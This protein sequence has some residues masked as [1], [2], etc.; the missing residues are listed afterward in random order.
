[1]TSF[2]L[3]WHYL[4]PGIRPGIEIL[5][6]LS[7][8]V[9]LLQRR[10]R[11]A[12]ALG[13]ILG[14]A[15]LP[16]P[17]LLFWWIVGFEHL[18]S[19]KDERR[20]VSM[21]S[22]RKLESL[23][24]AIPSLATGPVDSL[25]PLTHLPDE[26]SYGV[27]EPSRG[28]ET[29]LL[30]D[31]EDFYGKLREAISEAREHIHCL[32][33][34]WRH[35]ATGREFRDLLAARSRAGVRV[36]LLLDGLGSFRSV[37]RFMDPLRAAGASVEPFL[38]LR[39]SPNHWNVNFRNHR[40]L[41]VIDG[42]TGFLGGLNIGDE[43]RTRWHDLALRLRGPVVDQIQ[44]IFVDDWAYAT[45][46]NLHELRYFRGTEF[47]ASAEEHLS[48]CSVVASGP[49]MLLNVTLEA[50]FASINAATKRIWIFTP[51]FI[52]DSATFMALRSAV[53]RGADVRLLV[54]RRSNH[55]IA[56][57]AAKS[58]YPDLLRAG[59]RIFEYGAAFLHGK[60][61]LFDDRLAVIGSANFDVRS[62]RLNFEASCF[63]GGLEFNQALA[64]LFEKDLGDSTE[65]PRDGTTSRTAVAQILE[66]ASHLLSPL[67]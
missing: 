4:K 17:T 24:A 9:V 14:M 1:M 66:S 45:R 38:P 44:E 15:T 51:Y 55:L 39:P 37:G 7:I 60:A 30:V 2:L 3:A 19:K 65:I 27:F 58:Y 28:N 43:Y 6:L 54:P 52:P 41:V 25:L 62:F 13:W 50:F 64:A 48:S 34:I 10:G 46:E 16:I 53:F 21:N 40:K 32:F 57:T 12:A 56:G 29:R 59:V 8:P 18:R 22:F 67:L 35:D 23:R 33:Y 31:S 36:R 63:V 42:Q 11:P 47:R 20:L 61:I 26:L 5:A 49:D